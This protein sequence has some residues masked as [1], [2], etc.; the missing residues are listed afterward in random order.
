MAR[1]PVLGSDEG[2]WGQI[3][4]DF[5]SVSHDS[6]GALKG[7]AV[8][9]AGAASDSTVV[10][11][12][13]NELISGT[14]T[15]SA[16]PVIPS[17]ASGSQ[18]ANKTYVDSVVGAGAPDANPTTKGIVQLAGDLGGA[19][20]TA[21]APIITDGV[22]TTSKLGA[23]AVTTAKIASGAVTTAEI[24][25]GTITNTDISASAGIAKSK[26]AA[27]GIVDADVAAGAAIAK[28]KLAS[29]SIVD[30]DVSAISES[31]VTNLTTDLAAKAADSTVV[32][33]AGAESITGTKTFT[34]APVVPSGSFPE[35]AVVNLTTDLAG[36][37]ASDATLSALA[38]LD[39]TAGLVVE[40]AADV[41]TKR[42]L[43]AGSTKVTIAN[44][45]GAAGNPTIDVAEANFTGIPES[46]VTNLIT[47][48]AS[49]VPTTR[50][51]TASTGLS[52]GG[53]LSADRTLSVVSDTTTQR[54]RISNSGTLVGARQEVN[55][56]AGSNLTITP[57]D[58][59]VNNRVNVTIAATSQAASNATTSAP[60]LVQLA[61]DLGG[62]GTTATAPVITNGAVTSAKIASGTII[63]SNISGTAAIAKGK[64]ASLNIVDADVSAISESKVTNLSTDLSARVL[65]TRNITTGT[66]LTGGGDLSADRTLAVAADTTTQRVEVA[67]GGTLTGTRKRLNF[68]A[69]TNATLGVVDD[70]TNN[71]VD[72]TINA[73]AQAAS[74]ATASTKGVVQLAGDLGGTGTAAAAPVITNGAVTSA[75]IASGTII[76]ANISGTAAIAKSKLASLGIVDADVSAISESKI[77]NLTTDLAGKQ[78][79]DATLTALA[80]LD[81]TAGLVVETAADTFTKRTLTAGSSKITVSNGSGVAGNPTVDVDQTQLTVS[82][83]QVTNLTSD[84]ASKVSVSN[85]G[86]ETFSDAGNSSTAITLD[87]ANG[88]V[89]KLTL[90]ANCTITLTSPGSGVM[91]SLTLLVFQDGTGSRTITWPGSVKWG[92]AGA[93]SLTTTAAKMD[94]ISLFTIDGGTNWYG[95]LGAKGF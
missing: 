14:K 22:I 60:G 39:A 69:G 21:S 83:S 62:A 46:A 27:L 11:N 71:K 45:T 82:E 91:R 86:G 6:N 80:G 43:V 49:K 92:N 88:N 38:G 68:I 26:L 17:P 87:L 34:T 93:P 28:S 29:L 12:T 85:G 25:D 61:G 89:Q 13:G 63:D 56:V 35:S 9:D 10:H 66:G 18:A 84:L 42:T 16:S 72:I 41:F 94:M 36:K 20:S 23:N 70:S 2:V 76:D 65:S 55:L 73:S 40:T 57:T 30:A 5:L 19:G 37:Q 1:L 24:A 31:K 77:T 48:L 7:G 90:T 78:A 74:D 59:S 44:G 95:A 3:L 58:D 52:G 51:I 81:A 54:V 33:L 15:F 32:H 79:S 53:D 64:L 47:D 67:N 75:K 4:N 50:T 8:A